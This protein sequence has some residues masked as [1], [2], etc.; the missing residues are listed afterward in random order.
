A[1]AAAGGGPF[2]GSQITG[3]QDY[4]LEVGGPILKDRL[5]LWGSYG[6]QQIDLL[7]VTS[8][9][10]K[11]TL[12]DVNAKLNLQVFSN[13]A[14]TGFY[15]RGEK[16]KQGWRRGAARA[17][18]RKVAQSGPTAL[19]KIEDNHVFSPSLVADVF[20]SYMDEGF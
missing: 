2:V 16:P 4:G 9:P 15:L 14:L 20:Y 18:E 3:I 8:F 6:R 17:P 19:F 10:D 1:P 13:N 11:T 7:T 5:W 12:E